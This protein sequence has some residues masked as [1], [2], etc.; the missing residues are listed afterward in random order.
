MG[1]SEVTLPSSADLPAG[2]DLFGGRYR[3]KRELG[4]GG[5]GTVLLAHHEVLDQDVAIKVLAPEAATSHE[6]I[7]RL[8]REAKAIAK[9][10]SKHAVRVIDIDTLDDVGPYMVMDYLEGRNLRQEVDARGPLPVGEVV[11]YVLEAL[12]ALAEAHALGIVHRDL[13]P[14]NLFLAQQPNETRCVKVL[15]FGISKVALLTDLSDDLTSS[16]AL[17]GTPIYMSPEQL[18]SPRDVD[19]RADVWSLGVVIYE[20]VAGQ[21]PF[22]G[23]TVGELCFA[24]ADTTP[25][26]L[27]AFRD[28]VPPL[29]DRI[30]QR[31]LRR[32]PADRFMDAAELLQAL[33]PLAGGKSGAIWNGQTVR[34]VVVGAAIVASAAFVG[35]QIVRRSVANV[36]PDSSASLAERAERPAELAS[37]R[38]DHVPST[39]ESPPSTPATTASVPKAAPAPSSTSKPTPRRP[40]LKSSPNA[41]R[42]AG[43]PDLDL[44]H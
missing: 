41:K 11:D 38:E 7:I 39:N 30:V 16:R 37:I 17:L 25:K 3:I 43:D 42:P 24:I 28:D 21:T 23:N 2:T 34:R 20:L 13:K 40:S 4:R 44:R 35:W 1:V 36:P 10:K 9:L 12:D 27:R 18:R 5:M 14:S 8:R 6:F 33:L 22:K 19:A 26:P 15:D 32:D 29:L 31:C